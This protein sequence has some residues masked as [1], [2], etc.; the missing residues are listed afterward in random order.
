MKT[1]IKIILLLVLG[2]IQQIRAQEL[3]RKALLTHFNAQKDDVF[4]INGIL[5]SQNDSTTL[6]KKLQSI[7]KAK[8]A[9][10][11]YFEKNETFPHSN[12]N[13]IIIQYAELMTSK[14]I[15]KE[16]LDIKSRFN[17]RYND[18]GQHIHNEATDPV[19]Y[20][21]G[22]RIP[23]TQAKLFVEK[24]KE[25][26]IGYI[27]STTNEQNAEKYGQNAKNGLVIIWTKKNL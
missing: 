23:H 27:Y 7:D 21:N 5:F 11:S 16:I 25:K 6:D 22:T 9:A 10:I 4:V 19:L 1:T 2:Y 24:L 14:T 12:A 20:F 26:Q 3:N 13:I 18:Y 17:D 15:K 8:L